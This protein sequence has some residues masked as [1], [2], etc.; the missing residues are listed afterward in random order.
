MSSPAAKPHGVLLE[1]VAGAIEDGAD[2]LEVEYKDGHEEVYAFRGNVG[3]G[4]ARLASGSPEAE[5][6]R[7]ELWGLRR[8]RKRV[9]VGGAEHLLQVEIFDSFGEQAFRVRISKL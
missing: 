9:H 3:H 6:L 8:K 5:Q 7:E 1:F 4:M 2:Q